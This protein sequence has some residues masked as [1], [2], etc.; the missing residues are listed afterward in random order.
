[1]VKKFFL[2]I[3]V[4][5]TFL[6][7]EYA[8]QKPSKQRENS[9][10]CSNGICTTTSYWG[11]LIKLSCDHYFCGK[12][13]QKS[14]T[15]TKG[16][17][18]FCNKTM[19]DVSNI[20]SSLSYELLIPERDKE[21][22][23]KQQSAFGG[24][25]QEAFKVMM[26]HNPLVQAAPDAQQ[27]FLAW[28]LKRRYEVGDFY[29]QE[30]EDVSFPLEKAQVLNEFW[31]QL[32]SSCPDKKEAAVKQLNSDMKFNDT[33]HWWRVRIAAA[34]HIGANVDVCKKTTN[35]GGFDDYDSPLLRALRNKDEPLVDLLLSKNVSVKTPTI[36]W[37][38]YTRKVAQKLVGRGADITERS[39][40][41][42]ATILE[43]VMQSDNF[44]AD[45]VTFY[46]E[47][48]ASAT[49]YRDGLT[50][51]H[52][53]II[54]H[55]KKGIVTVI[56]K[57]EALIKGMSSQG[58]LDLLA[59]KTNTRFITCPDNSNAIEILE[60]QGYYKSITNFE[61]VIIYCYLLKARENVT[62]LLESDGC[63]VLQQP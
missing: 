15:Q 30:P 54:S 53:L 19:F 60:G 61:K 32:E 16:K 49:A 59:A 9:K 41:Y 34:A 26:P 8:D 24:L 18:A 6:A 63:K 57:F 39:Q 37:S 62:K 23:P 58:I 47:L 38:A 28:S 43:S 12:C 44:E 14:A 42:K 33:Y 29:Q 10:T 56:A 4:A 51:L 31:Q 48:G 11:G 21:T 13:A 50:P 52:R 35:D 27:M 22:K 2:I 46:K 45:L 3:L 36:L 40:W 7:L 20:P 5:N 17:C 1:M 25:I 55:K